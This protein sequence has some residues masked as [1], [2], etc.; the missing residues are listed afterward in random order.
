MEFAFKEECHTSRN[1]LKCSFYIIVTGAAAEFSDLTA[2]SSESS[3]S[4]RTVQFVGQKSCVEHICERA[5]RRAGHGSGPL[6]T[7]IMLCRKP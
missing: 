7:A 4:T 1:R 5:V 6:R 3:L 2:E